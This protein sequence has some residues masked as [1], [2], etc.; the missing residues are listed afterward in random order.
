[1]RFKTF[2]SV[3][4]MMVWA[5]HT[6]AQ[7]TSDKSSD[8]KNNSKE[9]NLSVSAGFS[10]FGPQ[11]D[12]ESNMVASGLDDTSEAGWFGGAKDHPFTR[13]YPIADIEATYYFTKKMGFALN[14]GI[15]NNIQVIGYQNI[16]IGNYLILKSEIWAI[17]LKY[18]YRFKDNRNSFSFG[19]SYF[20]HNVKE[21][22]GSQYPHQNKNA[23]LGANIGYSHQ[24]LQKK[25]WFMALKAN[26][27]WAPKSKIGPFVAEH[28]LG[29][30]TPNPQTY[31]SVFTPTKVSLACLNVGLC[32]GLRMA[33]EN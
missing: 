31:T 23:K 2:I 33:G 27:C 21:D 24:I 15:T 14:G 18:S 16:G 12:M 28:Q 3:I 25:H 5:N 17:S 11:N 7:Q 8:H 4:L 29:I 26:Y 32:I 30:A 13:I 19:P 6:N 1:M 10:F 22:N 20:I 9:F